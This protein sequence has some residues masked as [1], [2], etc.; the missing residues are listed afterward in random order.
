MNK[1]IADH[2]IFILNYYLF[3]ETKLYPIKIKSSAWE[4]YF[5]SHTST[6]TFLVRRKKNFFTFQWWL[7]FI[8]SKFVF[9]PMM[10]HMATVLWMNHDIIVNIPKPFC[11]NKFPWISQ[12]QTNKQTRITM[13]FTGI[14]ARRAFSIDATKT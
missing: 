14:F 6:T 2:W 8:D 11:T 9:N 13:R 1:I 12:I 7:L 10:L 5:V 3:L 4:F